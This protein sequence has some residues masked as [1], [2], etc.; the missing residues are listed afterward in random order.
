VIVSSTIWFGSLAETWS[1]S[2]FG[3]A[4]SGPGVAGGGVGLV[5]PPPPPPPQAYSDV[6]VRSNAANENTD[7]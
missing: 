7:R 1:A 2:G 4:T 5:L 3:L 6:A